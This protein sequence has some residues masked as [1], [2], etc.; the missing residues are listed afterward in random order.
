MNKSEP[1]STVLCSKPPSRLAVNAIEFL[2]SC[3]ASTQG[4]IAKIPQTGCWQPRS[5][6]QTLMTTTRRDHHEGYPTTPH[7]G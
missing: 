3:N 1:R 5:Q 4:L 6:S 2:D 7:F